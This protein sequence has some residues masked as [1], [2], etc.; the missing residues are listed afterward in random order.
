[1]LIVPEAG[2]PSIEAMIFPQARMRTGSDARVRGP[3]DR[4]LRSLV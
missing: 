1:V 4:N 3:T 2:A